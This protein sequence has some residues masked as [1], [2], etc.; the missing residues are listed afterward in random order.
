MDWKQITANALRIVAGFLFIPHGVQKLF[1]ALGADPA[2]TFSRSWWAGLIEF[3]GGLLILVGFQT[4][5]TAFLC[6]GL[7]AFAY[8]IAH[9]TD[10]LLPIV[11]DGELAMLYCFVF[12]YMWAHGG[13]DFS[14]DGYLRKRK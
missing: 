7:M 11:N 13:G 12:L 3:V 14:V 9:G 6:S 10:A 1:G 2:A 8:W 5:W 4:R